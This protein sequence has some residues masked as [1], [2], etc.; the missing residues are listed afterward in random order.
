MIYSTSVKTVCSHQVLTATHSSGGVG[1]A[2]GKTRAGTTRRSRPLSTRQRTPTAAD[3]FSFSSSSNSSI[4]TPSR[5]LRWRLPTELR[6]ALPSRPSARASSPRQS[7]CGSLTVALPPSPR[8]GAGGPVADC[9]H[10]APSASWPGRWPPAATRRARRRGEPVRVVVPDQHARALVPA[11]HLQDG[12]LP[13]HARL[14][15][16]RNGQDADRGGRDVQLPQVVPDR[17][18]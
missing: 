9:Q 5:A 13:Q 17:G 11:V 15:P 2:C 3:S 14:H 8:S 16:D 12:A 10:P 1:T 4:S 7:R 18:G 6:R